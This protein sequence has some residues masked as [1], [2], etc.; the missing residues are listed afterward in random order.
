MDV[1]NRKG[2]NV[3]GARIDADTRILIIG[4]G[5]VGA[6]LADDLTRHGMTSVTVVD[7]GPLYRTGGSSSHAPGFAFQTTGSAVMSELARRTL[8]KLD[9]LTLDGQW[10]LNWVGGLELACDGERLQYLRRRHNLL[11]SW[12]IPA[13]LVSPAECGELFPGL[14]TSGVVGGFHTPTDGVVKA[15]R[16]VEWQARRAIANGAKFYG[17]TEVTGF[18][19][20]HGQVTGVDVRPPPPF[21]ATRPKDTS[22][23]PEPTASTPISSSSARGCGGRASESCWDWSSPW[24]RWNT[25]PPTPAPFRR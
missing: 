16:A 6:A 17:H 25:A 23:P 2:D 20:D 22:S 5:V 18:R 4:A 14:D 13:Q 21:P 24:F 15:V 10:I 3:A 19:I 7:Q 11:Q 12:G 9:G 1:S 8:D